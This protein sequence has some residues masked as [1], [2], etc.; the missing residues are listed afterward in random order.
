MSGM[1]RIL[2]SHCFRHLKLLAKG[3]L[4]VVIC[5]MAVSC[6][7][8]GLFREEFVKLNAAVVM[9]DSV[10]YE[11]KALLP[12]YKGGTL[13]FVTNDGKRLRLPSDS[14][15]VLALE[16]GGAMA[17]AFVY[18]QYKGRGGRDKG[19]A[20]MKCLGMGRHLRLAVV[21]GSWHFNRKG[22]LVPVSFA[23]GDAYIIGL[24][25]DGV[26]E[27]LTTYGRARAGVIRAL[28]KFLAD[29][30]VLC[31]KIASKEIDAYDFEEICRLYSPKTQ[32]DSGEMNVRMA[33]NGNS[34]YSVE[35]GGMI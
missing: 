1:E 18:A 25:E 30:P 21:G 11:G 15:S 5:Q 6:S 28:C 27:Y 31:E 2:C 26:G 24:K 20:W 8:A 33:L 17:G 34:A 14:V 12:D 22:E 35:K 32:D 13:R 10:K 9:N 7:V 3:T 4:A 19:H 29:D 16:H 23:D